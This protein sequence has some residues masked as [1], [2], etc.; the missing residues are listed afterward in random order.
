[1][2]QEEGEVCVL[3]HILDST[4]KEMGSGLAKVTVS[5]IISYSS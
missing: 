1:M 4:T 5:Y 2:E 3:I